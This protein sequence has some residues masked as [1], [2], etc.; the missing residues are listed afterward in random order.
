MPNAERRWAANDTKLQ[1]RLRLQALLYRMRIELIVFLSFEDDGERKIVESILMEVHT[2]PSLF[3][4]S[5][6][7]VLKL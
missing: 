3:I 5:I 4:V 1:L 7:N 2:N 6:I